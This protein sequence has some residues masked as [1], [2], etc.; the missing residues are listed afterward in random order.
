MHKFSLKLRL[1]IAFS[2]FFV[3]IGSI[4]FLVSWFEAKESTDEFFDSYQMALAR[5]LASADWEDVN[6]S[7]LKHTNFEFKNIKNAQDDDEAIGFAVFDL[8]GNMVFHDNQNGKNFS[9]KGYTS[10]F[11]NEN[12][13]GDLWRI[14]RI[15]SADKNHIIAIGQE[16]EYRSDVAWDLTE[17]FMLPW[18]VGLSVLLMF[19]LMIIEREFRP[20]KKAAL[21]IK[22]RKP[23][24]LSQVQMSGLPK[25]VLPLVDAIN[26]LLQKL[27]TLLQTERRFVAD[28]S[29]ELRTPLAALKVQLEVLQL[30]LDDKEALNKAISNLEQ[31]L[32]R[33]AHLV[34]Q[35]LTLSRIENLMPDFDDAQD[36][37][38]KHHTEN[39]LNDY[40]TAIK[41]KNL[42]INCDKLTNKGPISKANQ[43]LIATII[44]NLSENAVKY[45]PKGANI[46]ICSDDKCFEIFNLGVTIENKHLEHLGKRFY[47]PSGNNEK[48]SGL[49]LSIVK[50]I[51]QHYNCDLSFTNVD[52][53]FKVR[54]TKQ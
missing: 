10:A 31:G 32:L 24:D 8:S 16:L 43:T 23:D 40:Q 19:M 53:G 12:V 2:T 15:K 52:N 36:I 37:N 51:V 17:E 5:N 22:N 14:M 4:C 38:W 50:H 9:F 44:K 27:Q 30:C 34:E 33:S 18:I 21:Q 25:E 41:Q 46:D 49:G 3:L 1:M 35:L 47:R 11:V 20:L 28:A 39:I 29:H 13:K 45:S 54:V 48:G 7:V 42:R 26:E 6:H